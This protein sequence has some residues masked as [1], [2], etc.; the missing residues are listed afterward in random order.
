VPLPLSYLV[1]STWTATA[2]MQSY[3]STGTATYAYYAADNAGNH[4]TT[5]TSGQTFTVDPALT[6]ASGGTASNSDGN[7]VTVPPGAYSG[8]LYI[9]ISTVA[10]SVTDAADLASFDSVKLRSSDLT[11]QFTAVNSLGNQISVFA[12]S[13]TVT[14]SYPDAN[15]DGYIDGDYIRESLAWI[16]YLDSGSGKWVPLTNVTRNTAANTVSAPVLHFSVYS[17]RAL[18]GVSTGLANLKAYPNP[19]DFRKTAYLTVTG[20]PVDA[21][22]PRV[23]I[24]N[25]AGELV[26]TL[27]PGDGI[28]GTNDAM[29]D[30]RNARN[31]KA[32]SGLY[33]YYVRTDNYGTAKGKF[34]VVW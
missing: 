2:F 12:S 28:N 27:A 30:G 11:R 26:R 17:V 7:S 1:G 4:G 25:E 6:N 29:W 8:T 23:Y 15:G 10:S 19:C 33:I 32:A 13:L 14:M 24:Y 31:S 20:I 34:F 22:N 16:Y 3:Y 18:P 21:A 9:T 5:V